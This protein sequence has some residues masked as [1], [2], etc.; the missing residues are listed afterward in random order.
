MAGGGSGGGPFSGGDDEGRMITDINVTPLVDITLVL[1][2]IFMVTTSYIVNPSIKV[3]L[4]RSTTGTEQ[5]KSALA[6]TIKVNGSLYLNGDPATE[7][8]VET[9]I[10][11]TIKTQPDLQALLAADKDVPHGRVVELI[12]LVR[13][14]GVR[15][16]AINVEKASTAGPPGDNSP[17][18]R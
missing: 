9:F 10:R 18:S 14:A 1:L 13:K 4:P 17:P 8:G 5:S 16:F 7:A 11:N 3:D 6:L 15:K 2:I 12:D